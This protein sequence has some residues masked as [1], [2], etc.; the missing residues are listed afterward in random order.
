MDASA[1][2][3][4]SREMHHLRDSKV[5]GFA[6]LIATNVGFIVKTTHFLDELWTVNRFVTANQI[7]KKFPLLSP[8]KWLFVPPSIIASY[9]KV[10]RMNQQAL[11]SRIE[12]RGNSE[13]LDHFEQLLPAEAPAPTR[14]ELKH[15]EVV[16]GHLVIAGYEPIASQIFCTIMFSLL[17]P[18]SLR[19]LVE[20]IRG[21]FHRYDNIQAESLGSLRFLHASLMETL[22]ITVLS[23]NGMA[24][25]SPGAMVDGNYIGKGVSFPWSFLIFLVIKAGFGLGR[26]SVRR[27]RIYAQ[28]TLL[29]RRAQ[30]P[31]ATLAA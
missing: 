11:E 10:Q 22:R 12:R 4:Y 18:T 17:E 21:T 26:G 2:L 9:F 24:R 23:S 13:H 30:V 5:L 6:F 25:T 15:I 29:S 28:S 14:E 7:F 27:S 19:L 1:D 3:A 8:I 16:T 31:T 20:E